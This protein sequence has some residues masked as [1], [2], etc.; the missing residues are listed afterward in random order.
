MNPKNAVRII[1]AFV[2]W[3]LVFTTFVSAQPVL[4]DEAGI[5]VP[6]AE[7]APGFVPHNEG[8]RADF[9]DVDPSD[10][11]YDEVMRLTEAGILDGYSD[12]GFYPDKSITNAEFIKLLVADIYHAD[13]F[14]FE[15][16]LFSEHWASE[17]LTLAYKLGYIVSDDIRRGFE[18]DAPIVRSDMA[19]F[20][21]R[22]LGLDTSK[23][24]SRPFADKAD[25]Y[26]CTAFGEYLVR[27]YP[28]ENGTRLFGADSQVARSEAAAMV[29]RMMDYAEDTYA[30]KRE[31]ILE[32]AAEYP[33]NYDWELIDL[34]YVL[35]RELMTGFTFTT[36]YSY[37]DWSKLYLK[38]NVRNLEYFYSSYLNCSYMKNSDVYNL[39]LEYEAD[40]ELLEAYRDGAEEMADEVIGKIITPQMTDRDKVTAIHDYL[41]LN[42]KYDYEN[43]SAGTVSFESRLAYGALCGGSAVCQG[44][45]AAFNMLAKKVGVV[46]E[47]VTGTAPGNTDVHAWNVVRI[48]GKAL[49]I[50]V[51]HDD[52]VPDMVGYVSYKYFL[53]TAD[54]MTLLGYVW[55]WG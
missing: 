22:A 26:A 24:V 50:D 41:V 51:T 28:G 21:V 32:N 1:S 53:R 15:T 47:V 16:V 23:R 4:A 40:T 12:G 18:P 55:N 11:Y 9:F 45:A 2:A 30:F 14:Q 48:D 43:Y 10:W 27:G 49:Y 5:T 19:K 44:Y 37:A 13:R 34:F 39:S 20:A 6:I 7:S 17:Y 36:P 54:E 38:S 3:T 29:V 52:P 33:L 46:S 42:C 31:A 25:E 35:N 8:K